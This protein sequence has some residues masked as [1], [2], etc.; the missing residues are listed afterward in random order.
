MVCVACGM[1]QIG[2]LF[3]LLSL[4]FSPPLCP[5]QSVCL[6]VCFMRVGEIYLSFDA[7]AVA[8]S[9]AFMQHMPHAGGRT[10]NTKGGKR[11]CKK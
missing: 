4:L 6:H 10:N 1:G 5:S 9:A 3:P 2:S 7:A 8:A 11:H